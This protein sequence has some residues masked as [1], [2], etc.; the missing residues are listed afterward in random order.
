MKWDKAQEAFM[1]KTTY[2]WANILTSLTMFV[3]TVFKFSYFKTWGGQ[4]TLPLCNSPIM[5]NKVKICKID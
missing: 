1:P 4:F 2:A 3:T 5:N